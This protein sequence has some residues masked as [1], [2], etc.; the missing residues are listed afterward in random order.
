MRAHPAFTGGPPD[1]GYWL[2]SLQCVLASRGTYESMVEDYAARLERNPEQAER[3]VR[4]SLVNRVYWDVLE[5]FVREMWT[6]GRNLQLTLIDWWMDAT[7]GMTQKPRHGGKQ[8][9]DNFM[10]DVLIVATV[11]AIRNVTDL[12]YEFDEP[13]PGEEPRTACH[14]VAE[15]LSMPYNTVRTIWQ[16][17]R[18]H[19]DCARNEGLIPAAR[20]RRRRR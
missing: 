15:R 9:R 4:A 13:K 14:S 6:N 8:T 3:Y 7:T 19:V 12:P 11:D 2:D 16:N 10:R 1:E 5:I 17:S 18:F 20:K